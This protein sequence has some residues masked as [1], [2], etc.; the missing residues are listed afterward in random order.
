MDGAISIGGPAYL[1]SLRAAVDMLTSASLRSLLSPPMI[2]QL[3]LQ[4][5][6]WLHLLLISVVAPP[7]LPFLLLPFLYFVSPPSHPLAS[8]FLLPQ[9]PRLSCPFP[10]LPPLSTSCQTSESLLPSAIS[11]LPEYLLPATAGAAP[12]AAGTLFSSELPT[13]GLLSI[14]CSLPGQGFCVSP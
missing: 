7:S 5:P 4:F 8:I 9:D 1:L 3:C 10:S 6:D 13:P 2:S 14:P 12:Q 11:P